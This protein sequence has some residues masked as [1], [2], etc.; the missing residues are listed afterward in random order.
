MRQ[1]D[2]LSKSC[3]IF[4][5]NPLAVTLIA[6]LFISGQPSLMSIV[7]VC[8]DCWVYGLSRPIR[9]RHNY[10]VSLHAEMYAAGYMIFQTD[11]EIKMSRAFYNKSIS[12]WPLRAK[13]GY[14]QRSGVF[15]TEFLE[16][17]AA[18]MEEPLIKM[19]MCMA[20]INRK[21]RKPVDDV[22]HWYSDELA[23]KEMLEKGLKNERLRPRP[24][25]TYMHKMR[26]S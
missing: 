10:S 13:F 15:V 14:G 3:K 24:Q 8:E 7:G 18:A 12:K 22:P 4:Q 9:E 2:K 23:G 5:C 20:I 11:H 25:E 26:V 16:L 1:N 17:R 21:T 6:Y 19:K